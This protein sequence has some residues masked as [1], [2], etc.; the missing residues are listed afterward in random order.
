M[1]K[2]WADITSGVLWELNQTLSIRYWYCV[3]LCL[4]CDRCDNPVW[5]R[6]FNCHPLTYG[7]CFSNKKLKVVNYYPECS[8][9]VNLLT[10]PFVNGQS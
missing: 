10:I 1:L 6:A 2:H 7:M 5:L 3:T 8:K 9:N 4:Y